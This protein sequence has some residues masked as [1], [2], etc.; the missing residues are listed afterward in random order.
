MNWGNYDFATL[1]YVLNPDEV[2]VDH[3][4]TV[5]PETDHDLPD[6]VAYDVEQ[7]AG[8]AMRYRAHGE[9]IAVQYERVD[10]THGEPRSFFEIEG[11]KAAV[12][13]NWK[14]VYG[15]V[16]LT[17]QYDDDNELREEK[18]TFKVDDIPSGFRP[19]VFFNRQRRGEDTPI[20]VN[21]WAAFNLVCIRSIYDVDETG[22]PT[23]VVR[24]EF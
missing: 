5:R 3:A 20:A 15:S 23:T 22:T 19:F 18:R 11:R 8:A 6:G 1:N 12:R 4:W 14:D 9:E 13:W 21:D 2:T 16:S 7:H 17:L 10:C 24:S